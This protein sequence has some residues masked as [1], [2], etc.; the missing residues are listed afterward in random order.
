MTLTLD[1]LQIL[2]AFL[3]HIIEKKLISCDDLNQK[4]F[5]IDGRNLGQELFDQV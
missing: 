1:E 3:S 2:P 4:F 5:S